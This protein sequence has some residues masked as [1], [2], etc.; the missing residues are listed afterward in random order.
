MWLIIRI[1]WLDK[2]QYLHTGIRWQK[3]AVI[4]MEISLPVNVRSVSYS[5]DGEK[6]V[7]PQVMK[8]DNK[9]S[10]Q[11]INNKIIKQV[12]NL[13]DKQR[14]TQIS[15][16]TEMLATYEL[17][18]NQ[19]GVL[20]LIQSNYAYTAPMAHG[21]T[22]AD[23]L[24]FSIETGKN[25][26]LSEQ[27]KPQSN[28]IERLSLLIREQIKQRDIPLLNEFTSISANQYYYIAD[29]ALVIYFQ[30]YELSPYYVGIPMFPISVYELEDI[31]LENSPLGTMLASL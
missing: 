13:I 10:Q 7:Y 31:L 25:Y 28:F 17:K 24:T 3:G 23:S 27:F 12:T 29:K 6:M 22:Y 16:N 18:T 15:G 4:G 8:L 21:M 5:S 19:R 26:L 30:L 2:N 14:K 1:T 20:S 9:D 11:K